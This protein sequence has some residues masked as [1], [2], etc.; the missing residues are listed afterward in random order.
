MRDL[1]LLMQEQRRN[2]GAWPATWEGGKVREAGGHGR[3]VPACGRVRA[4]GDPCTATLSQ[5]GPRPGQLRYSVAVQQPTA[6]GA[7]YRN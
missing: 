1:T 4:H 6:E 5:L 7:V 2:A 3:G